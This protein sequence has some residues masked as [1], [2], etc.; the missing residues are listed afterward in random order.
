MADVQGDESRN[1]GKRT[2]GSMGGEISMGGAFLEAAEDEARLAKKSRQAMLDHVGSGKYSAE[3]FAR[4]DPGDW[5][6]TTSRDDF[7]AAEVQIGKRCHGFHLELLRHQGPTP[8]SNHYVLTH[9]DVPMLDP[10]THAVQVRGHVHRELE[11]T[12]SSVRRR[13][14][15]TTPVLMACAGIGRYVRIRR[16]AATRRFLFPWTT[17][18]A[19]LLQVPAAEAILDSRALGAG[20]HRVR[21]VDGL[22]SRGPSEGGWGEGGGEEGY[23]HRRGQGRRG[24]PRPALPEMPQHRGSNEG[25]RSRLLGDERRGPLP[26]PRCPH[27]AH[28][29]RVVR[30]GLGEVAHFH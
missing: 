7:T 24:E 2:M 20:R 6:H 11:L 8:V 9:Y 22:L 18:D 28:R 19:A 25:P 1:D 13:E 16:C 15:I 12:L 3:D 10:A 5:K 27:Q 4:A 26:R 23:L 29:P 30:H 21:P 17:P 14:S